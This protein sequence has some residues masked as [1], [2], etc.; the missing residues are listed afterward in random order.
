MS[1]SFT[2]AHI[3]YIIYI[4]IYSEDFCPPLSLQ[5]IYYIYIYIYILRTFVHL[6][7]CST[8]IIYIYIYIYIYSEDFCPPLSLQHIICR[9]STLHIVHTYPSYPLLSLR[10][11]STFHAYSLICLTQ[12]GNKSPAHSNS[13]ASSMTTFSTTVKRL[14]DNTVTLCIHILTSSSSDHSCSILILSS[15]PAFSLIISELGQTSCILFFRIV[16]SNTFLTVL[17]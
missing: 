9:G 16:P 10:S 5:H 4:Y 6:F 8:Y 1:T 14:G 7:H 17:S 12:S 3:L 2:A 13:L 11:P 15:A